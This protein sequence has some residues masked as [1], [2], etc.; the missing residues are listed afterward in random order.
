EPHAAEQVFEDYV[1]EFDIPVYRDQ[2][3]DRKSGV[4]KEGSRIK[5]IEMETGEVYSGKM[6]L[7]ATYE[8]DLMAAAGVDYHVGR[9]STSKY[10]E[11]SNGVQTGVLHHRH[12]FGVLKDKI[13]PYVTPGD[14]K[15][16]VLP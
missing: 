1:K 16:G 3:L 13:N 12:H 14:P 11:K 10:D 2:W 5:S 8:G 6:F 9:E 4:T 7:D 15:S